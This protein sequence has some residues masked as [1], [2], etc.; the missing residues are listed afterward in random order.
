MSPT[1]V[2]CTTLSENKKGFVKH[3]NERKRKKPKRD[4]GGLG[5]LWKL[6]AKKIKQRP[7]RKGD[8]ERGRERERERE[9]GGERERGREKERGCRKQNKKRK[10]EVL[11][12]KLVT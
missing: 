2:G 8:R 1:D 4:W 5:G 11:M 7:A 3:T 10:R 6:G 12:E 9:R